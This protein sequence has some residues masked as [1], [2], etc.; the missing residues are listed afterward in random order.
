VGGSQ[1]EGSGMK[2]ITAKYEI[3]FPHEVLAVEEI[4]GLTLLKTDH[5]MEITVKPPELRDESRLQMGR[6]GSLLRLD[7]TLDIDKKPGRQLLDVYF[8]DK[9]ASFLTTFMLQLWVMTKTDNID[10]FQAPIFVKWS[11]LDSAGNEFVN[12]ETGKST[13]EANYPCWV[14]LTRKTWKE[15]ID[16]VVNPKYIDEANIWL[17]HAKRALKTNHHDQ[18]I[19]YAAIACELSIK[20]LADK[21]AKEGEVGEEL[22]GY[23]TDMVRPRVMTYLHNVI[24]AL[25]G[26]SLR[27]SNKKLLGE[28][29]RLFEHRNKLVHHGYQRGV[30]EIVRYAPRSIQVSE[31]VLN[32][33]ES[34]A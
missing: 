11:Y 12:P 13:S 17:L 22:W 23:L 3:A 33:V 16:S 6:F 10:P 21:L 24:P 34:H 7:V 26:D 4:K 8:W 1:E 18:A 5:Q 29:E 32:W 27:K 2:K 25:G 31:Q 9:C 28:V 30:K 20:R 19:I 14:G 15:V